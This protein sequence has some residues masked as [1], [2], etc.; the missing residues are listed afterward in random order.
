M[1]IFLI[2]LML[3]LLRSDARAGDKLPFKIGDEIS[4]GSGWFT[5]ERAPLLGGD[6]KLFKPGDQCT[7][8]S[9]DSFLIETY[10]VEDRTVWLH[11]RIQ[12]ANHPSGNRCPLDSVVKAPLEKVLEVYDNRRKEEIEAGRRFDKWLSEAIR[13]KNGI[14]E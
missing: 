4:F 14:T 7:V 5:I 9:T 12:A 6:A 13:R 8:V 10:S 1:R 2:V 11:R 3:F